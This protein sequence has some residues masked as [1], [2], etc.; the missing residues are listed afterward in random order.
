[1]SSNSKSHKTPLFAIFLVILCTILT[2]FGQ[3]FIKQGAVNISNLTSIVS[4]P[5]IIGFISYAL[6]SL[7][8]VIALKHGELSILYPFVSLSFVWVVLIGVFLL[9]ESIGV[10]HIVGILSIFVGVILTGAGGG[11]SG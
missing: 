2:S 1:M 10:L 3:Y 11:S 8:L 5:L 9:G 4:I 6:G 7:I